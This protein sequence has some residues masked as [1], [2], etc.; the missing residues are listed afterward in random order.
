MTFSA[1]ILEKMSVSG[2][3]K[4]Y[5][6]LYRDGVVAERSKYFLN[7]YAIER[8]CVKLVFAEFCWCRVHKAI[9]QPT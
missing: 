8:E 6:V 4:K 1:P 3:K 7:E 2:F 5:N 9:K